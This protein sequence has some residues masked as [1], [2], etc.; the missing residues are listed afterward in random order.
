[1]VSTKG[2]CSAQEGGSRKGRKLLSRS[3]RRGGESEKI[4]PEISSSGADKE[5]T[6]HNWVGGGRGSLY[7]AKK[8]CKN[9]KI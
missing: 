4:A 2:P 9:G 3:R 1:V 6:E 5:T 8:A 7:G